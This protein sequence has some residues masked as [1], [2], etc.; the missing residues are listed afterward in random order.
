VT[1]ALTERT[2]DGGLRCVW[3]V[4]T[5]RF[6]ERLLAEDERER[7]F[8]EQARALVRLPAVRLAA[9]SRPQ[10]HRS[11]LRTEQSR[12]G[13]ARAFAEDDEALFAQLAALTPG[14]RR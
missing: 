6:V 4:E 12:P 13:G 3:P 14:V 10:T 5:A 2:A 7:S 9:G 1:R 8:T 11:A